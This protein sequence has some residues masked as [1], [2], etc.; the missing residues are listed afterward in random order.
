L[1]VVKAAIAAM[2]V[3]AGCLLVGCTSAAVSGGRPPASPHTA[4]APA[5]AASRSAA[6]GASRPSAATRPVLR[7]SLEPWQLPRAVS[8]EVVLPAGSRLDILGGLRSQDS[9]TSEVTVVD[10]AGRSAAARPLARASHDAAGVIVA[11]RAMV[12]GGGSAAS[13]S[14]IQERTASGAWDVV[15]HLPTVRSDLAAVTVRGRAYVLGGYDGTRLSSSVLR[16]S[17]TGRAAVVGRLPVPVRY[18]AV[19]RVGNE[20][21]VVGGLA[22]SGPTA[23]VQRF[24]VATARGSVVGRLRRPVQGAV[25]VVLGGRLFVCGG[26]VHGSPTAQVF[27]VDP[28]TGRVARAGRLPG[29]VSYAG[30]TELGG[31]AYLVGGETPAPSARVMRLRLAFVP[32]STRGRR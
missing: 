18:A 13:Q 23:V 15:G 11:G 6:T 30:V 24:D 3:G 21:W 28:S 10:S 26:V 5:R 17:S 20:I 14:W 1:I 19:A 16:V 29:P 12:F 22:R 4:G 8:R 27:R 7:A 9:T 25:A 2:T 32:A 31:A